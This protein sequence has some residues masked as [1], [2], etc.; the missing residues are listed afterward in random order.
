MS[1]VRTVME[2]RII[3]N[4]FS[5]TRNLT[6]RGLQAGIQKIVVTK[7]SSYRENAVRLQGMSALECVLLSSGRFKV[8][9]IGF[10][11]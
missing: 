6:N 5:V 9:S 11:Q 10:I 7:C 2:I 1:S 8:F 4:R 3:A